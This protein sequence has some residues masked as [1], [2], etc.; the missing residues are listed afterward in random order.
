VLAITKM[1]ASSIR[2]G[3]SSELVERIDTVER[4]GHRLTR[5][6]AR[7]RHAS[8]PRVEAVPARP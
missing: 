8:N 1:S 4:M 7:T 3:T 6:C 5:A 2:P